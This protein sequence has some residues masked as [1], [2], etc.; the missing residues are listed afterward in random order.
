MRPEDPTKYRINKKA[1]LKR[2][3]RTRRKL[4]A[5][6]RLCS[7][8]NNPIIFAK[9]WVTDKFGIS[10]II[11]KVYAAEAIFYKYKMKKDFSKVYD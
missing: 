10:V 11:K 9:S 2:R 7:F 6:L 4:R 1:H 8:E 5:K 3:Y